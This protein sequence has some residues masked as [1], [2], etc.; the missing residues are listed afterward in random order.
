MTRSAHGSLLPRVT[1]FPVFEMVIETF[2]NRK[3]TV[4]ERELPK[5]EE[6]MHLLPTGYPR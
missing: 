4:N 2:I 1:H 5:A 6:V 3:L